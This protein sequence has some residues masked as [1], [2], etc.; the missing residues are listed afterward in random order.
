MVLLERDSGMDR[1]TYL[2]LAPFRHLVSSELRQTRLHT[3][4]NRHG[5]V[6]LW[7][8]KLPEADNDRLRRMTNSALRAADQAKNLWTKLVWNTNLGA[9]DLFKAKGDLGASAMAGWQ[10]VSG[11]AQAGLREQHHR[12]RRPPGDPRTRRRTVSR[13]M[14]GLPF[15]R[16]VALDFEFISEPGAT[17]APICL[18][19]RELI[20]DTLIRLRHEDLGSGPPFPVD[21]DTLYVGYFTSAE[22]GCFLAL[23]WPPPRRILDLYAEFRN[24]TNG[25]TLPNGRGLLAALS[26]H[27]IPSIT[28]GQKDEER[29]LVMRGGPYSGEERRRILDYCQTDVDPLGPC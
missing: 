16:I 15:G 2:V 17:P 11:S 12:P 24:A 1:E 22:W 9:Y 26:H 20:S 27:S 13:P 8:V 23:G 3:A 28:S 21:D 4:I 25:L 7:P 18:V 10:D 14:L 19:A 6:F 29:A 5:T